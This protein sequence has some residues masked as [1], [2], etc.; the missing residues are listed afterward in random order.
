MAINY[1]NNIDLNKNELQ[2]ARIQVLASA[3]V[4]PVTGQIYYDSTD[5]KIYYWNGSIWV[6]APEI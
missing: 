2:N 3:P 5:N 1:L 6:D 4:S